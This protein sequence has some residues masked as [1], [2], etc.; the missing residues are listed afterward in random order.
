MAI[1]L[2]PPFRGANPLLGA[3]PERCLYSLMA[4]LPTFDGHAL[5]T[6]L[7]A[8][9]ADRELKWHVLA[10]EL[11]RQSAELNAQRADNCLCPGALVRTAKRGTMSCQYALIL[12]RW[13]GRAP[14]EFLTGPVVALPDVALPET[15]SKHRLRWDL[16]QLHTALDERRR[17]RQLS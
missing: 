12:L 14:E 6:A 5:I 4:Q 3:H 8:Q 15:D 17:E 7:D 11:W 2:T 16:A 10:D 13:L 1:V 9:R